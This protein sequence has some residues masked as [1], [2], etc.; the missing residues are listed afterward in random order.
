M[1]SILRPLIIVFVV[2]Y[3]QQVLAGPVDR[4]AKAYEKGDYQ[5]ALKEFTDAQID[6]PQRLDLLYNTGNSYYK[7]DQYKEA[8]RLF[9][10]VSESKNK[11]L[12]KKGFYNR[13]NT[14]YRQGRLDDA[15]NDYQKALDV[16]PKDEDAQ[17][18][19][20]FVR[21]EIER[22]SAMSKQAQSS[23]EGKKE[24][25]SASSGEGSESGAKKGE[26][27]GAKENKKDKGGKSKAKTFNNQDKPMTKEEAERWLSLIEEN[28]PLSHHEE[29]KKIKPR[30][31]EKDW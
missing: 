4:G 10:S 5:E 9:S 11:D 27:Q 22:R 30:S 31:V 25:V 8:N 7:T 13:G 15:V 20:D 3:S 14:A 16:D 17:F 19:L 26:K 24:G 1:N 21:R 6:S 28:K 23:S 18:N 12:S 2:L 29:A